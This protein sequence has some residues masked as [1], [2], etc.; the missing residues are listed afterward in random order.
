MIR[1]EEIL[2]EVRPP[3][4]RGPTRVVGDTQAEVAKGIVQAVEKRKAAAAIKRKAAEAERPLWVA[5]G[6]KLHAERMRRRERRKVTSGRIGTTPT[7][8]DD[9]ESG[10]RAL[11]DRC[12]PAV[13]EVYGIDVAAM[14]A[15]WRAAQ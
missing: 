5:I 15:E 4:W 11:P 9:Y 1:V 7:S 10:A 14:V 2:G 6:A 3:V 12:W 8:L 13:L